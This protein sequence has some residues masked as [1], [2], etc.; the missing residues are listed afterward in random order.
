MSATLPRSNKDQ[1]VTMP[2]CEI[3][4]AHGYT[5]GMLLGVCGEGV[6]TAPVPDGVVAKLHKRHDILAEIERGDFDVTK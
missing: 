6:E 1:S 3:C 2:R 5:T 4:R